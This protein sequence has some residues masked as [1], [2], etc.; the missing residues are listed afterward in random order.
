M[1]LTR[2][3][4]NNQTPLPLVYRMAPGRRRWQPVP[5]NH[6]AGGEPLD[7]WEGASNAAFELKVRGAEDAERRSFPLGALAVFDGRLRRGYSVI[8]NSHSRLYGEPI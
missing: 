1:T 2:R 5:N 8:L 7:I 3:S 6:M 4:I